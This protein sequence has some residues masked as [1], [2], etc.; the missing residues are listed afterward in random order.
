MLEIFIV[1]I[2][3]L[4]AIISM[5]V[6]GGAIYLISKG[7]FFKLFYHNMMEWHIPSN[8][9][10]EFDGCNIQAKC[11]I[12]GKSIMQDSQGNWF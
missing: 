5:I 1:F 6:I 7:K 2:E 8:E 11:K 9:L 3:I 12:C 10:Q 4:A